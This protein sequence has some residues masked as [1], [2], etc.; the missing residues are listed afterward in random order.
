[1]AKQ[2]AKR[3]EKQVEAKNTHKQ[4]NECFITTFSEQLIA[5]VNEI[6]GGRK[7]E[8]KKDRGVVEREKKKKRKKKVWFIYELTECLKETTYS[9][10]NNVNSEERVRQR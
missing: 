3:E 7:K 2:N 1:M 8:R 6:R 10:V 4:T 5:L 9:F